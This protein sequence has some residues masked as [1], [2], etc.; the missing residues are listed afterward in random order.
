MSLSRKKI[1]SVFLGANGR[2]KGGTLPVCPSD[3]RYRGQLGEGTE[4]PPRGQGQGVGG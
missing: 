3:P 4:G 1:R 2:G